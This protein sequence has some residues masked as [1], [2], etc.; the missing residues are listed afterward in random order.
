MK[1]L[2]KLCSIA[3]LTAQLGA[4]SQ[5]YSQ[6]VLRPIGADNWFYEMGGGDSYLA[7]RQTNRTNFNFGVGADWRL[8]RGCSFDPRG[9]ISDSFSDIQENIY[10][11]ADNLVD[12]AP[13]ML[14]SWGLSKVQEA[15]PTLYDFVMNGAKDLQQKFQVAMK[16]CRDY[17]NDLNAKRD[18]SS[19][20]ISYGKSGAWARASDDGDNPIKADQIIDEEAGEHGITWIDGEQRAGKDTDPIQVI[21]EVTTKGYTHI[22]D[23][24]SGAIV[25]GGNPLGAGMDNPSMVFQNV[26]SARDWTVS[27][28]GEREVSMCKECDRLKTTMGQGLRLKLVEEK[29]EISSKMNSVLNSANPSLEELNSVSVPSMGF[30]MTDYMV[31][32]IKRLE[33][34]EREIFTQKLIS[35]ISM[36]SVISKA[37]TARDILKVGMQE[38]NV[39]ANEEAMTSLRDAKG[40][41]DDEINNIMFESEVRKKLMSQTALNLN[42]LTSARKST[43]ELHEIR[44]PTTELNGL[45]AGAMK[46]E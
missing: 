21:S 27:V 36:M 22:T 12:S 30:V 8:F 38:P 2:T 42:Q 46:D 23:P 9:S 11:L 25:G 26:E 29:D 41:L 15:Y 32:S 7:Y 39:M 6:E 5:A 10:G 20:W 40:V 33:D 17:Q 13:S 44:N 4:V 24:G 1:T 28:V 18:P 3:V 14:Q 43:P 35:D 19:G 31:R 16:S 34:Y 45:K 37:L